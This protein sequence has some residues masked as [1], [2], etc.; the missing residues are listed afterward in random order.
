MGF[1]SVDFVS[2]CND[3]AGPQDYLGCIN[4][5]LRCWLQRAYLEEKMIQRNPGALFTKDRDQFE[6]PSQVM[7]FSSVPQ[8]FSLFSYWRA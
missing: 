8:F 7:F 2:V 6:D 3:A 1:N 4:A 5:G